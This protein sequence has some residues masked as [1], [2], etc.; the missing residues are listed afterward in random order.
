[1]IDGTMQTLAALNSTATGKRSAKLTYG[2]TALDIIG[3]FSVP[4]IKLAQGLACRS[5]FRLI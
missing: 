1:M 5:L 4:A 3:G 2:V